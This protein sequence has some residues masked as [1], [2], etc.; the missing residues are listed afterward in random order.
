MATTNKDIIAAY[1]AANNIP[2]ETPLYTY[3]AWL[4]MGYTVKNGEHARH[5]VTL[6]KYVPG[7]MDME[8]NTKQAKMFRKTAY[9]FEMSQVE[10][11]KVK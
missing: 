11:T 10:P 8:G 4:K 7:K 6:H 5:R 1:K 2:A 9:L 3:A